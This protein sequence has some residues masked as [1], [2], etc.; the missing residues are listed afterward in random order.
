ML[1]RPQLQMPNRQQLGEGGVG[2]GVGSSTQGPPPPL[3]SLPASSHWAICGPRARPLGIGLSHV[4]FWP[5]GC[6]QTRQEH[7]PRP[8]PLLVPPAVPR[9]HTRASLRDDERPVGV[10]GVE[11]SR[12]R[13]QPVQRSPRQELA[14]CV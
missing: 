11:H 4:A 5:R 3:L 10:L 12:P 1:L 6:W 8:F 14:W 7:R 9:E 2:F 13:E